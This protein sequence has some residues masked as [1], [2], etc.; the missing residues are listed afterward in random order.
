[1]LL[2]ITLSAAD[3]VYD[4]YK[5]T[6]VR[7]L[8][9]SNRR[10][11][12]D[13]ETGHRFGVLIEGRRISVVH[14]SAPAV[15]F[16]VSAEQARSLLTR[17]APYK[18]TVKGKKISNARLQGNQVKRDPQAKP[19]EE[20]V[21]E[22]APANAKTLM[23]ALRKHLPN[24]RSLVYRG[25]HRDLTHDDTTFMFGIKPDGDEARW[26]AKT[27]KLMVKALANFDCEVG[28]VYGK[29]ATLLVKVIG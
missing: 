12:V 22:K 26:E 3:P 19:P 20:P 28:A 21:A 15:P 5:F 9:L 17:S 7:P 27:E 1:M 10:Y 23:T 13:V 18:G 29:T 24:P 16:L 11:Q 6:G 4:W 25:I 2:Y 14:E 8:H